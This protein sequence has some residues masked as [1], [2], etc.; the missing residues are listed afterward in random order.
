MKREE[1]KVIIDLLGLIWSPMDLL[2]YR[3]SNFLRKVKIWNFC[4][5]S[6]ICFQPQRSI[7][8]RGCEKINPQPLGPCLNIMLIQSGQKV[9]PYLM[10]YKYLGRRRCRL[11][12][13]LEWTQVEERKK[14]ERTGFS[15]SRGLFI[16]LKMC[17]IK[18]SPVWNEKKILYLEMTTLRSL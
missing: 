15:Q 6:A 9:K 17:T 12:M 10:K 2:A 5:G 3:V 13:A 11:V 14:D 18:I 1:I 4:T 8:T 16:S 7:Y